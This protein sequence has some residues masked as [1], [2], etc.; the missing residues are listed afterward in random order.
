[1]GTPVDK[2][3]KMD[4]MT[5]LGEIEDQLE[6]EARWILE[7]A[8]EK[9]T[10]VQL[11]EDPLH[12][13]EQIEMTKNKKWEK[14]DDRPKHFVSPYPEKKIDEDAK[15]FLKTRDYQDLR[16]SDDREEK[17]RYILEYGRRH[18]TLLYKIFRVLYNIRHS[19]LEPAFINTYRKEEV[20]HW[21]LTG[22]SVP[23]DPEAVPEKK[24]KVM[25]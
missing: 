7:N 23:N 4:P 3:D 25:G 22:A 19:K 21:D 5:E 24:K 12:P 11:I 16:N 9:S 14:K 15:V 17:R 6:V 20:T 1:M 8:F 18:N 13:R 10:S 2:I